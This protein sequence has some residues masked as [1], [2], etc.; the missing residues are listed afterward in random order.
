MWT[1]D[2]Q[3]EDLRPNSARGGSAEA[4]GQVSECG[5]GIKQGQAS[6][7]K[8]LTLAVHLYVSVLK[9]GLCNLQTQLGTFGNSRLEI[10]RK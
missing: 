10:N 6:C 5:P 7:G 3:S 9:L 1:V 8:M 4:L 2:V